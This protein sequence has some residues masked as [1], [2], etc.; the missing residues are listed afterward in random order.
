MYADVLVREASMTVDELAQ[1]PFSCVGLHLADE[2]VRE[3]CSP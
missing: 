3:A 1:E 2:L